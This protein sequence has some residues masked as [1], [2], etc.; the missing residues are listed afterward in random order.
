[1]FGHALSERLNDLGAPEDLRFHLA[2]LAA[3][4]RGGCQPFQ[5]DRI[6]D[7]FCLWNCLGISQS[8]CPRNI[9]QRSENIQ[10]TYSLRSR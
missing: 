6:S 7:A 10:L 4:A 3:R 5:L 8:S 2:F 9:E 1:M